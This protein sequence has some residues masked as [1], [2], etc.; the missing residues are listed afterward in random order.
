[1]FK[2]VGN[3]IHLSKGD[4]G[5]LYVRIMGEQETTSADRVMLT[6]KTK[7]GT[8]VLAY[9]VTPVDNQALFEFTN[10]STDSLAPNDY[11]YDVRVV[12]NATLDE[13]GV[14]TDGDV[15]YTPFKPALFK[16]LPVVGEV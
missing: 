10:E 11:T 1:M 4:T 6:V 8:P 7:T 12:L 9:V 2:L 14:P 5:V 15:V 3:D 13:R 16:L